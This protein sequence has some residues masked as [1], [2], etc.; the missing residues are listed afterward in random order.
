MI[1]KQQNMS[2]QNIHSALTFRLANVGILGKERKPRV[3]KLD[4]SR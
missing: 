1:K 3:G 2:Q 4:W